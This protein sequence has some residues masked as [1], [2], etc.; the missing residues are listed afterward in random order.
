[1]YEMAIK[2]L[3]SDMRSVIQARI[4]RLSKFKC[5]DQRTP[6]VVS[7]RA[8]NEAQ[9]WETILNDS[10]LWQRSLSQPVYIDKDHFG[11][12]VF[13][14]GCIL[15][16]PEQWED[17]RS[18]LFQNC[19]YAVNGDYTADQDELLIQEAFDAE[20]RKWE[21]LQRKF[22]GDHSVNRKQS[23]QQIPEEVRISV[24]RRDGGACAKCGSRERLEYDHI[25]PVSRGGSD[26][27]RNI[28]LLCEACNRRK[29]N[30]IQ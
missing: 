10:E 29:S 30:H 4:A 9:K 19:F 24:W 25:I 20:R 8:A 27:V 2:K 14:F 1:M 3:T 6:E 21:R 7:N 22:A 18:Y 26:T 13:V 11:N 16:Y 15:D 28:E 12:V 5:A 17:A 23:R